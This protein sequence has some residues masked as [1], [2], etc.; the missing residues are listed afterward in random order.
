METMR[1]RCRHC[2]KLKLV[3]KK[4]QKYCSDVKCQQARKNAWRRQKYAED[5]DYRLNQ[6]QSTEMWLESVGGAAEYYREYRRK[7]KQGHRGASA[8]SDARQTNS[9]IKTGSYYI[10]PVCGESYANSDAIRVKIE[11]ITDRYP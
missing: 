7:R 2:G 6:K 11:V 4:G 8:N 9:L 1:F 5:L 3:V 10:F